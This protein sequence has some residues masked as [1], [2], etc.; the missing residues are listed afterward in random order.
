MHNYAQG[1]NFYTYSSMKATMAN[2]KLASIQYIHKKKSTFVKLKSC[3]K[4]HIY[5]IFLTQSNKA[6]RSVKAPGLM[7]NVI[8]NDCWQY[9][10]VLFSECNCNG[11]SD[12][13]K[14]DPAVFE[15]SG[16][17]SGGVCLNCLHNTMG[18]NCQQCIEF[19]YQDPLQ[20]IR[21]FNICQRKSTFH[22]HCP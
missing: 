6:N 7:K 21:S 13:C 9:L 5:G 14:F 15:A 8:V 20:D 22:L 11:H 1:V 18:R 3:R 17:V 2:Y 19:Y 12:R 4:C 16:R 10:C